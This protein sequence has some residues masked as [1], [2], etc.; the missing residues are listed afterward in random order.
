MSLKNLIKKEAVAVFPYPGMEAFKVTLRHL[1]KDEANRISDICS[2]RKYN[3]RSKSYDVDFDTE[4]L[5]KYLSENIV[6]TWEG[7]TYERLNKLVV[8]DQN[9]LKENE[10]KPTDAFE[11]TSENKFELLDSS[12]EFNDWVSSMIREVQN[13]AEVQKKEEF[14][15]LK[16]TGNGKTP[17]A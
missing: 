15:N 1:D 11:P 14:E 13:F 16:N 10:I 5:K 4:K 17:Q 12:I 6:K 7:L 9:V 3:V 8:L 2:I